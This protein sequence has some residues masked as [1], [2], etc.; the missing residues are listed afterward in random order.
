MRNFAFVDLHIDLYILFELFLDLKNS[1][2]ILKSKTMYS[3]MTKEKKNQ[4]LT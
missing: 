2:N 3:I 4:A 1:Q